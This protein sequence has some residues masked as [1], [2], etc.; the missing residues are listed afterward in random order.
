MP[1]PHP[2]IRESASA[3]AEES[4]PRAAAPAPDTNEVDS[5]HTAPQAIRG[6]E[7]VRQMIAK[8]HFTAAVDAL[9]KLRKQHPDSGYLPYLQ[10][11]LYADKLWCQQGI[12]AYQDAVRK[13]TAYRKDAGLIHGAIGCLV[14]D[15]HASRSMAFLRREIGPAAIPYLEQARKSGSLGISRR[16]DRLLRELAP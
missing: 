3:P 10:G 4:T 2:T 15:R 16:S 5:T 11:N 13:D 8:H 12:E 14:S 9:S 7:Q 6:L 1:D